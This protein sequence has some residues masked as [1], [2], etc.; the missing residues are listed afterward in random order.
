MKEYSGEMVLKE[1]SREQQQGSSLQTVLQD[2]L[3]ERENHAGGHVALEK[4]ALEISK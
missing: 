3:Q 1:G 4:F 2:G